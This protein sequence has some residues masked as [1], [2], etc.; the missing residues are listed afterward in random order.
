MPLKKLPDF[1]FMDNRSSIRV[2]KLL[3]LTEL[4]FF[5]SLSKPTLKGLA[6]AASTVAVVELLKQNYS[7]GISASISWLLLV[8]TLKKIFK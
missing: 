2:N 4:N 8:I 6:I 1:K 5:E 7:V 3:F